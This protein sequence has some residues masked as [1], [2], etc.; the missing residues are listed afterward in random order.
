MMI[1]KK[2]IPRRTFLRGAGAT[3]GLPL[4]DAM[5]PAMAAAVGDAAAKSPARLSFV[6]V[7]N[8]II[9]NQW[10]PAVEG[11]SFELTPILKPL[12]RFQDRLLVVSGLAQHNAEALDGEGSGDHSRASATYLTGVHPRKTEGAD[13]QAGVSVDQIVAKELGKHTQLASLELSLVEAT[14]VVGACDNGY[15]CAYSNTLSWRSPTTPVPME[16]QPRE[17]FERLFGDSNS[18]NPVERLTRLKEDSSILDW[19]SREAALFQAKLG[20]ND[21]AKVSEYLDAI[22]DI[23]RRIQKAEEQNSR[24]L[25][26]LERPAGIPTTF[27]EHAKLMFDLQVLAYQSDMTRVITFMMGRESSTRIYREIG[28]T[29]EHH[30]LSHHQGESDKVDKVIKIDTYHVKLFA[31]FLEKLRSTRDGDGSLL[32][33]MIIVYGSGISDG[34]LHLHDNL[35]TLIAGGGSN[36][37]KGGRHLRYPAN[38]PMANLYLTLMDMMGL[39]MQ[40]FGDST[41]RLELLSV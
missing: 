22:R 7:P 3:L 14:E 2:A 40:Q 15:S 28:I 19:V 1:F 38:T 29:D 24:E 10:T 35:P 36:R 25:P 34:N 23:E 37:I 33:N 12:A 13:I 26:S 27:E 6:Y 32:D 20:P 18:T 11:S 31:Y 9:M 4:L 39:P 16:N 30:P 21:R 17:V 8:G 5:I 41:G